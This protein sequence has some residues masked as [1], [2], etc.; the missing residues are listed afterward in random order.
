MAK[1]VKIRE[2]RNQGLSKKATAERTG[3][4]RDTVSKY[5]EGPVDATAPRYS[6]RARKTDPYQ[7]YIKSRLTAYPELSAKRIYCEIVDQGY[8]GSYRTVRRWVN[9]VRPE[10]KRQYAPV[11][12]LPG[13]QAQ[14]DWGH[15]GEIVISNRRYK[16]Y[17]FVF[18]LSWSRW[19][20]IEF[21]VSLN[22]A[23]FLASL[24]RALQAAGGVPHTILFDNAKTVVSERV[25]KIV[26]FNENLLRF[27]LKAGF[28]P[29]ACWAYDPES[30][31]KVES[32]V[33]Y[34]KRG[35]FYGLEWNGLADLAA[36]AQNWLGRV[37]NQRVHG[38]T[39]C[40][41]AERLTEEIGYLKPL[42][43]TLPTYVLERRKATKDR[44]ISIDGNRYFIESAK[45]KGVVIYRRY[46]NHIELTAPLAKPVRIPLVYG[47]KEPEVPHRPRNKPTSHPLQ[48]SF[49]AL[50][51]SAAEY[52]RGFSA[53]G[54]GH[55][56]EHM[57]RIVALQDNYSTDV[58]DAAFARAIKYKAYG[59]GALRNIIRHQ[60]KQRQVTGPQ[61]LPENNPKDVLPN[62]SLERRQLGYYAQV[63][64]DQS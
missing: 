15:M 8:T 57:Q 24:H 21:V 32:N 54:K 31:G 52:L 38:T 53:S 16:L 10:N 23:T 30:K 41:P 37:A 44:L 28:T 12:T 36:K 61:L 27:A 58:L 64:S 45:G 62:V 19:M 55:L 22:T 13:E 11:H 1:I 2:C 14:V 6:R 35:F 26:R 48:A 20:Y 51:P 18:T 50:A 43:E 59:Y 63:G 34:V 49:E 5:W 7:E 33:K 4:H 42:P 40:V 17:A 25:G 60:A 56:R 46:E 29:E 3:L 47:Y 39:H 9:N